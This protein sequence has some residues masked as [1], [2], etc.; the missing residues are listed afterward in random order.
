MCL[1]LAKSPNMPIFNCFYPLPTLK[2]IRNH[3]KQYSKD[4]TS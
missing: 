2:H 4:T 1:T 3:S